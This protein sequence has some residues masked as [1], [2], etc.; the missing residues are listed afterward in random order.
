MSLLVPE[1]I[2]QD[3]LLDEHDAPF[4]PMARSLE[5][6]RRINQWAGGIRAYRRMLRRLAASRDIRDLRILDL[7]TGTSDLPS[8]VGAR[9]PA[10][11]LDWNY[12]HLRYGAR[13]WPSPVVRVAGDAFRLPIRDEAVD[14]V[15]SSHFAHHFTPDENVTILRES[16]RVSRLG[17]AVTDTRRHRVP[18]LFIRLMGAIGAVGEITR[19]DGPASVVRGYTIPE[20]TAFAGKAGAPRFEI[21]RAM[22]FRWV[23]ILWK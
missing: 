15:T 20:V 22:P 4:E 17:V 1:R 12:R 14:V 5:D 16:L 19:F 6:L 23:L 13:R 21:G 9:R 10:I 7:G 8:S 2:D 18:L 11:G 3:E